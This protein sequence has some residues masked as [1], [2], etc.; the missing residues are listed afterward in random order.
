MPRSLDATLLAAME[1]G[2]YNPVFRAWIVHENTRISSMEV[3]YFKLDR[4]KLILR[5]TSFNPTYS[6]VCLERGCIIAGTEYTIYSSIFYVEHYKYSYGIYTLSCRIIY[7]EDSHF[8][9]PESIDYEYVLD[10]ITEN[11]RT[12]KYIL[13]PAWK[14]Y[15][16]YPDGR[17]LH[18]NSMESLHALLRQ[19]R[20]LFATD[21]D[22]SNVLWFSV[23]EA[24]A[25]ASSYTLVTAENDILCNHQESRRF[26]WRDENAT[27]HYGSGS[28]FPYYN[29]G[30]LE[31]TD[32]PP[33]FTSPTTPHNYMLG[34]IIRIAANLKYLTSDTATINGTK[35]ILNI[36]ECFDPKANP[37]WYM[38]LT[39]FNFFASTE[40]GPLPG[41]I[42]Q[43]APY[44]PLNTSY[45]T[46]VL[47]G[48]DNNLQAAMETLDDHDHLQIS[49]TV[50]TVEIPGISFVFDTVE[51]ILYVWDG[52]L[53]YPI[54]AGVDYDY[55]L[56]EDDISYLLQEDDAS[57]IVLE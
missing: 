6:K 20:L 37:A 15:R 33:L 22:F 46:W 51:R 54:S 43:S 17:G 42:L 7:P 32:D 18:V 40:G 55:I 38:E 29:L 48:T 31:S 3:T 34:T 41:T 4:D 52:S 9:L 35:V 16:F 47:D 57:K 11:W 45:F 13:D 39:S 36:L 10:Y 12:A 44:T 5:T 25:Q 53:W 56:L 1:S 26:H 27:I 14:Y 28:G 8:S 24:Y 30:Y 2:S 21:Y 50:P 49:T 19:K 23:G